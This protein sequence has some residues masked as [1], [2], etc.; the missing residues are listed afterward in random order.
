MNFVLHHI[1]F[2]TP[3]YVLLKGFFSFFFF[4]WGQSKVKTTF[5][6]KVVRRAYP[7]ICS[8]KK[9]GVLLFFQDSILVHYG[10]SPHPPKEFSQIA[11]TFPNITETHLHSCGVSYYEPTLNLATSTHASFH[12]LHSGTHHS[13]FL[14]TGQADPMVC[15][16]PIA[17]A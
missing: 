2:N 12:L 11:L 4:Q 14:H 17:R 16:S 10:S 13:I 7:T 8:M 1:Y 5:Q 9:P 15:E 3:Q 6:V